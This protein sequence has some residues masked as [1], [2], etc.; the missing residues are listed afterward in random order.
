MTFKYVTSFDGVKTL[1]VYDGWTSKIAAEVDKAQYDQLAFY[2][3]DWGDFEFLAT[4][5]A[6]IRAVWVFAVVDSLRGLANLHRLKVLKLESS[7]NGDLN[8]DSFPELEV[9]RL[10]WDRRYKVDFSK[11]PKLRQLSLTGYSQTDCAALSRCENLESLELIKGNLKTLDGLEMVRNLASLTLV[12]V[13]SLTRIDAVSGL[14]RLVDIQIEGAQHLIEL[15]LKRF[16][17]LKNL[18]IDRANFEIEDFGWLTALPRLET[19]MLSVPVLKPNWEKVFSHSSLRRAGFRCPPNVGV[20]AQQLERIAAE[21]GKRLI[22]L[23]TGK[24]KGFNSYA[25]EI[26]DNPRPILH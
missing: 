4:F 11:F 3:G 8:F 14:P 2:N 9:L 24:I 6:K 18:K 23:V 15:D 20:S 12:K 10:A 7:G 1:A 25:F 17:A 16:S 5:A 19:V 22:G 26:A 21:Q 13:S